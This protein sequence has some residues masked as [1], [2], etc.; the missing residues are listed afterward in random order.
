ME[1]SS[2][3]EANWF[4]ASPEIPRI[5]GTRRFITA[6][7]SACHM[8]LSWASLIQSIHHNPFPEDPSWY[9]PPTYAWVSLAILFPQVSP[10]KLCIH[11]TYPPYVLNAPPISFFSILSRELYLMSS[12]DQR[13]SHYVVFSTLCHLV[14]FRPYS[15]TPTVYVP[16]SIWATRKNHSSVYLNL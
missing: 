8:A 3:W 1:H 14:P 11:F 9:Y 2:S 10:P 16:P 12:T 7:T 4:L 6:F 13:V 5:Y 15:Q